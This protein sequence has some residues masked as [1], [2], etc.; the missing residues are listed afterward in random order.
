[1]MVRKAKA[2][3]YLLRNKSVKI[4]DDELIVGN[5]GSHRK[6]VIIQPELSGVVMSEELLW[7]NRR[8]T[9]PY[10]VSWKERLE[11]LFKVIPYWYF[12]N[13][14]SRAFKWYSP[15]L[16]RFVLEQLNAT[17]YLINESGGIGH[18]LPDYGSMIRLG[19]KG[20]METLEESRSDLHAAALIACEGLAEYAK[21]LSLEAYRL[22]S[23]EPLQ[24]RR[25]ELLDIAHICDKVPLEPA[26]TL[27]EALQALW[28]THMAVCLEGINSAVSFGRI[29]QYLYPFYQNDIETGRI[30]KD[31]ALELLLCFSAKTHVPALQQDERIPR[32][33]PGGPGS[34][35][36]RHGPGRQGCSQRPD[37]PLPRCHGACGPARPQLHG[38]DPCRITREICAAHPGCGP[39]RKQCAGPVQR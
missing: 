33:I 27:H 13:M 5:V 6:S 10:P 21:R 18:F 28:L 7:M 35:R 20:F 22:A 15:K 37:L 8:K 23:T 4:F 3:R 24:A 16:M 39:K 19:I 34:H 30:D 32:R 12:R 1:M 14:N 11:L 38:Q 9:N 26:E 25:Q 17:F 2:L 36:G 29:D 31:K